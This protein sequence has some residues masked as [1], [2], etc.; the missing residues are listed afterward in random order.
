VTGWRAAPPAAAGCLAAATVAIVLALAPAAAW[1][2]ASLVRSSPARRAVLV[3]APARVQLWFNERLEGEFSR[4]SVWDA[5]GRQVD[6]KDVQVEATEPKR[7][8]VGVP[9]LPPGVYVVRFR[10]LSVDGHI[11]EAEFPFTVGTP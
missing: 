6:S 5:S 7:L 8:S 4:L 10:V 2:H 11:V 9:A 3:K 1:P